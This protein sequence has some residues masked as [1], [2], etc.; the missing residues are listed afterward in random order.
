M[1]QRVYFLLAMTWLMTTCQVMGEDA[2]S[3]QFDF[4][5]KKIRPVLVTHCYE[6]HAVNSK[7]LKGGLLVDSRA[8]LL[9]GGESGPAVVPK[10]VDESLLIAALRYDDFE[11][12][13]NGKLPDAVI[14]DFEHWIR[15]GGADPRQSSAP[16]TKAR[17][18]DIDAG[19]S[20]WAYQPV[21][22]PAVPEVENQSWPFNDVDRFILAKLEA[23]GLEPAAD[24]DKMTLA[25]RLSIGLVGLPPTPQ[26]IEQFVH[27]ESPQAYER[28][29]DSL[30]NS[31]RFGERWGRHWLDVVRFAE[32]VTLRGF[33]FNESWRYRDYV[34]ESFNEDRPF[35]RFVTEQLA[36]D[37]LADTSID[38]RRRNLIATTFLTMGNNNL[39]NQDKKTLE[40]DFIDEQLDVIGRGMLAQTITCARCHDHKFDPIPTRDYYAMAGILKNV[41]ALTHAN[42]SKWIEVPLPVSDDVQQKQDQHQQSVDSLA[43]SVAELKKRIARSPPGKSII[44]VEDLPGVVV[45]D[46]DAR[47]VGDWKDSQSVEQYVGIGYCHDGSVGNGEKSISFMPDLPRDGRYEVRFAYTHSANRAAQVPVT[48]FSADGEKTINVNQKNPPPIDGHFISLGVFR[49]EVAGQSFVMVNNKGTTGAVVADAVQFLPVDEDVKTS[50]IINQEN[51]A[52]KRKDQNEIA[53]MKTQL[54]SMEKEFAKLKKAGPEIPMAMSVIE[55]TAGE[56]LPIHIRGSVHHLGKIAPRG[57]LQVATGGAAP[58]MPKHGSGRL[59]LARWM[60]DP[61][62]PLTSRVMVNRVWHWLIG[63]GLVSTVDNFGTTGGSPSHPELLDY[64]A[65][66]FIQEGWSVKQ[67]IRTIVLSR[68]FGQSSANA[69]PNSDPENRLLSHQNRNRLD[70]ESLR[71]AM[72]SAA[73]ILDLTMGGKT[74]PET[75]SSDYTYVFD[76]P[77]RSVYAPVFRNSLPEV[78]EVFDFA[79]PSMVSGRRNVST[80]APQAL[81]LLNHPFVRQWA[82]RTAQR[83]LAEPVEDESSRIDHA[84]LLI[85]SRRATVKEME[86]SERFLAAARTDG[87]RT[88]A[89]TQLVQSMFSSIEFRYPK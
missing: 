13:P 69:D 26:E 89:W 16:V 31:P 83:L 73:G 58:A 32:S 27:D 30:L 1:S 54:A 48:V 65:T 61:I 70:A 23:S 87:S 88:E 18:I 46:A 35:D 76:Q 14:S 53:S 5:E 71:D 15:E 3:E 68:S 77:R 11:M 7:N 60:V 38:D 22:M 64:L 56:D 44:A 4:F 74:Y 24:A 67:L 85:F 19:R 33:V 80:V 37:L 20:H 63:T 45:D 78:F 47:K 41:Q 29:V 34:I 6:C 62:H 52:A 36:G 12:P 81:F 9:T 25:R 79:D 39:E 50:G 51:I 59:E 40:M 82:Q 8:G 28:L 86:L 2:T 84:Y 57:V 43:R 42:I 17:E 21:A 49:F 66:Q 55:G 10:D 72:L 75:L